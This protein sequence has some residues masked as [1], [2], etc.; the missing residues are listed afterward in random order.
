MGILNIPR[1]HDPLKQ[2]MIR[3]PLSK[4][5]ELL[6]DQN[7]QLQQDFNIEEWSSKIEIQ[8]GNPAKV[9]HSEKFTEL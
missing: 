5:Q 6:A 2:S 7:R 9:F 1:G 3:S 8:R 4:L